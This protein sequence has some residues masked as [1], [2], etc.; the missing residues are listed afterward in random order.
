LTNWLK[1]GVIIAETWGRPLQ[2]AWCSPEFQVLNVQ[3]I[4][5]ND[6]IKWNEQ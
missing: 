5:L 6:Q 4:V 3:D 1:D 2:P